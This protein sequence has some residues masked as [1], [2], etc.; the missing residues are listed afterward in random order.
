VLHV[1]EA[2]VPDSVH[3]PPKVPVW[4]VARPTVPVGVM[5]VPGELSVTVT[6]HVD[7]DPTLMGE[8]QLILVV[9]DLG[10]T[11]ILVVPVLVL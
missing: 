7:K 2:V 8:V 9:V 3:V 11:V 1:A 6:L 5:K 4:L 10:L